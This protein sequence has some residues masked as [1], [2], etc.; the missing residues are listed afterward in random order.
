MR[1]PRGR[2][3]IWTALY[4]IALGVLVLLLVFIG[5]GYLR[6]PAS[7]PSTFTVE[8]VRWTIEQGTIANGQGWFGLGEF[9]YS[10]AAGFFPPTYD[11]GASFQVAWALVNYDHVNHTIYSVTV[12][13]PFTL[14]G[15]KYSLPMP[16]VI[17]DDSR[18]LG[19]TIG[20]PSSLTGPV[21]LEI[22]VNTLG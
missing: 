19:L 21:V 12:N 2:Q 4:S 15:T 5:I 9:N 13:S 17:G 1:V 7:S 8:E 10:R 6:L 3:L 14:V 18:P 16:V 20:S 11:S 22:T